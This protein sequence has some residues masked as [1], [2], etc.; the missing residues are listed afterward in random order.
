MTR[1]RGPSA[2]YRRSSA[3]VLYWSGAAFVCFNARTQVRSALTPALAECL[4][5]LTDW[6]D[7][8][9]LLEQLPRLGD[10]ATAERLLQSLWTAGLLEQKGE[11]PWEWQSWSPEASFFHFGTRDAEYPS[12]RFAHEAALTRR[13]RTDP[14]PPPTKTMRGRRVKMPAPGVDD[15]FARTLL[16]RRT[17]RNFSPAAIDLETLSTLLHLTWGIQRWG[18][19]PGQGKVAMKTSPSGGARHSIEA[20]VIA[21][22]VKGLKP[23]AYHYE[24]P[25]HTLVDLR[26]RVDETLVASV[27]A[28]Q[29]YFAR[30]AV[31]IVMSAVFARAMWRYPYNR[32]YRSILTEAG[33]LAQTFCLLATRMEL[34]PYCTMAFSE[35]RAESLLGLDAAT[36]SAIYVVGA[37]ARSPMHADLPGQTPVGDRR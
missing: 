10:V 31:V 2:H 36:E 14:P 7:R 15:D 33:H 11:P 22:N 18:T 12:D 28:G 5:Q 3:I 34:A 37:G 29:D 6:T 27:L 35:R 26:Q 8:S 21:L 1:G 13:A 25:G 32:A 30:S 4:D 23:G 19:V 17:W 24:T 16:E 9:A 20:Y